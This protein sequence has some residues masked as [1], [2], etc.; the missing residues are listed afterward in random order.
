M[1]PFGQAWITMYASPSFFRVFNVLYSLEG[2]VLGWGKMFIFNRCSISLMKALLVPWV[3]QQLRISNVAANP[4]SVV[5]SYNGTR[6]ASL[7]ME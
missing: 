4:N 1:C 7:N 6:D 2:K 5:L 3:R